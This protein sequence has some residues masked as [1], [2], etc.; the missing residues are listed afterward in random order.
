MI[1]SIRRS[2]PRL[3]FSVESPDVSSVSDGTEAAKAGVGTMFFVRLSMPVFSWE[4]A[5]GYRPSTVM[6]AVVCAAM[7]VRAEVSELPVLRALFWFCE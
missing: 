3:S 2:S 1:V 6:S 5:A 4:P 7:A